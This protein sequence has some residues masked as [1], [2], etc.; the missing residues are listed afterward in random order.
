MNI[1]PNTFKGKKKRNVKYYFELV[2][3]CEKIFIKVAIE[4]LG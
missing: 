2:F 3:A 1:M 4:T